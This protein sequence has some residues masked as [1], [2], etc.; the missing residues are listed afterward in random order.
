MGNR[1]N[2]VL[3]E[4]QSVEQTMLEMERD[5]AAQKRR[6]LA[7]KD[8]A[9]KK[10]F[11]HEELLCEQTIFCSWRALAQREGIR[12]RADASAAGCRERD[13]AHT[14]RIKAL[15]QEVL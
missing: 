10:Y 14:E 6:L 3:T 15:E 2:R 13:N 12:S 5:G 9:W 7:A 4:M 11:R 1:L 8:E